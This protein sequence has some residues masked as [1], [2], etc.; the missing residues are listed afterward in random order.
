MVLDL[1]KLLL[2]IILIGGGMYW[3][4]RRSGGTSFQDHCRDHMAAQTD[5]QRDIAR[6]LDRIA[7][8]LEQRKP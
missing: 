8:A 5:I 2:P 1:F 3:L 4:Y 7:T 6:N